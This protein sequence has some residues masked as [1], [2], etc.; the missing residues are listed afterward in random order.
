M[1][2]FEIPKNNLILENLYFYFTNGNYLKKFSSIKKK[3]NTCKF[4]NFP[5]LYILKSKSFVEKNQDDKLRCKNNKKIKEVSYSRE[6]N[7]S[8]E[9]ERIFIKKYR[10]RKNWID[11]LYLKLS[12][13]FI[14][15]LNIKDSSSFFYFNLPISFFLIGSKLIFMLKFPFAKTKKNLKKIVN[16]LDIKIKNSKRKN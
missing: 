9:M 7:F 16:F 1:F 4:S 6:F 2:K 12:E 15:K 11:L 8:L 3:K 10:F 14:K 13:K 5:N